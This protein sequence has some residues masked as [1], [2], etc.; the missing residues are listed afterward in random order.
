[1][2][3]ITI[4]IM[5]KLPGKN[6]KPVVSKN[7]KR[8]KRMSSSKAQTIKSL[9]AL[10]SSSKRMYG[11]EWKKLKY[12][13]LAAKK[14]PFN[15]LK[16]F[17][18]AHQLFMIGAPVKTIVKNFTLKSLV[19]SNKG[20]VHHPAIPY[21]ELKKVGVPAKE[22]LKLNVPLGLLLVEGK[23]SRKELIAAGADVSKVILIAETINNSL[24]KFHKNPKKV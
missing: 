22:L 12:S 20:D 5:P 14:I 11:G 7:V 10:T 13:E 15:I 17:L 21:H 19:L 6:I 16:R 9:G 8:R 1:M 3:K 18:T 24:S 23:Y 2:L 4:L